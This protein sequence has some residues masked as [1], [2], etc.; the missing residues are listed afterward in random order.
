MIK[1]KGLIVYWP[2][3]EENTTAAMEFGHEDAAQRKVMHALITRNPRATHARI[4]Q[5]TNKKRHTWII[6]VNTHTT[7][8]DE[9]TGQE[10][11]DIIR[12]VI[13]PK[14]KCTLYELATEI[15]RVQI[16][17]MKLLGKQITRRTIECFCKD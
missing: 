9:E 4:V 2:D 3:P 11:E 7:V 6:R 15:E 14:S 17:D 8:I 16:D 13:K 12:S 1:S 5:I 10:A